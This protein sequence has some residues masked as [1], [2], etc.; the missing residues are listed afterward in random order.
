MQKKVLIMALTA[1]IALVLAMPV[2]AQTN[3]PSDSLGAL[4]SNTST[5]TA[6][7][8]KNDVDN[9]MNYYKY[10]S[11]FNKETKGKEDTKDTK[12]TKDAKEKKEMFSFLTGRTNAG[13]VLDAGFAINLD[14][15]YLGIWYR[16]NIYKAANTTTSN[17][18]TP[19]WDNNSETLLQTTETTS[20]SNTKWME[21]ANQI[22]FLFGVAGHGIKVGFLE[23]LAVDQ[24]PGS[25][26]RNFTI[27]DYLD[28]R[29]DYAGETVNYENSQWYLKPYLG[30]G[31]CF[32]VGEEGKKKKLM[33]FIDLGL[34][35]YNDTLTDN[36]QNYTTV[37]GVKQNITN[38]IAAGRNNG[39][40]TPFGTIGV[41][42]EEDISENA[43]T[44]LEIKY[45]FTMDMYNNSYDASGLSG[46][47]DGTV[48]WNNGY[49]NLVTDYLNRTETETDIYLTVNE[50][51]SMTHSI[52]PM[53]KITGKPAEG[54]N[55][56][57][58]A[59]LPVTI[60]SLSSSGYSE[61]H[62]YI[63]KDYKADNSMNSEWTA[64]TINY[65]QG[66]EISYLRASLGLNFGASYQLDR[67]TINAGISAIPTA[68]IHR[69]TQYLPNSV[70]SI[71]TTT[72]KDASGTVTE[73]KT[74]TAGNESDSITVM[75]SWNQW[76]GSLHGGFT[77]NFT[78]KASLDLGAN[79]NIGSADFNLDLTTVNVIFTF[80]N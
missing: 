2:T 10:G 41:R 7:I 55:L 19:V 1:I 70:S 16:G 65:S 56:G 35:I 33:P 47:V 14:Q 48:R 50:F 57:F 34:T 66:N 42:M 45:G 69:V 37:N 3:T 23:W 64:K 54:L 6:G 20:Y 43:K 24:N 76:S 67:F 18:I 36:Y 62:Q 9:F 77:F 39:R 58:S 51:S 13:G 80:K 75:D 26:A 28:G 46:S 53:Y 78:P 71:T 21:S 31:T 72:T 44:T 63:K 73:T 60:S 15:L 79:S 8:F 52:T 4:S 49:V 5:A 22:E 38:Y 11:V 29:K 12:D 17:T 59:T 25:S 68:Y 61:Q 30:W 27:T 74:V 40:M 32:D